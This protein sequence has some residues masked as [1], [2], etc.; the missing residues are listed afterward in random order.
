MKEKKLEVEKSSRYFENDLKIVTYCFTY[1]QFIFSN[2]LSS[3][4]IISLKK[5]WIICYFSVKK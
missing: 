2:S 4:L 5:W 1:L 3:A